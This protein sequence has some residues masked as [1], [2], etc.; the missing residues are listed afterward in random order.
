[1]LIVIGVGS[2][3]FHMALLYE[4]QLMDEVP[5]IYGTAALGYCVIEVSWVATK[6]KSSG[7]RYMR[8]D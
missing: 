5:M 1:M 2:W 3:L 8:P 4:M 7:G 6:E